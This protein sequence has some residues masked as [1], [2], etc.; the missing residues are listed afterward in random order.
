VSRDYQHPAGAHRQAA[1]AFD[2]HEIEQLPPVDARSGGSRR[3]WCSPMG[4]P[5]SC[6]A[7]TSNKGRNAVMIL[8]GCGWTSSR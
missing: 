1:G 7:G 6:R 5:E 3:Y 4:S 2:D 8:Y